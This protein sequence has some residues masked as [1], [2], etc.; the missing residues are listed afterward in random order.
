MR[1]RPVVVSRAPW[2]ATLF[3]C[4]DVRQGV[5]LKIPQ[6]ILST[7]LN[8]WSRVKRAFDR[9]CCFRI[10][11]T[12]WTNGRLPSRPTPLYARRVLSKLALAAVLWVMPVAPTPA[13]VVHHQVS[14]PGP[15]PDYACYVPQ[16][17]EIFLP[18]NTDYAFIE[19][20]ELGHAYDRDF[21]DAGERHRIGVALGYRGW[22]EE[23]FA[24]FYAGCRLRL[25]PRDY[26]FRLQHIY[27]AFVSVPRVA[28]R[29]RMIARAAS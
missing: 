13:P 23:A 18:G 20:H 16:T 17:N 27:G 8:S 26:E 19:Q 5:A 15:H 24:D 6:V 4:S 2:P 7:C 21:L 28:A 29:C 10:D 12:G 11:A 25:D 9:A 3:R 22:P 14:C 1:M